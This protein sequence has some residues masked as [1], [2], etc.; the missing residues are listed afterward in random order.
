MA[1]LAQ[2]RRFVVSAHALKEM[3]ALFTADRASEQ[4]IG[5]RDP[6]LDARGR[7][8]RR[9]A[10]RGGA[11]GGREG[12]ARSVGADGGA[13]D[14]ASREIPRRG[15]RRLRCYARAAG[16]ACRSAQAAGARRPCCRADQA[17]IEKFVLSASRAAREGAA[18]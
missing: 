13:V 2:S 12:N 15:R 7:L 4:E 18:A 10:H 6:R 8:L 5:R 17:Q 16:L 3:R 11:G 9:S 1:S 14:R